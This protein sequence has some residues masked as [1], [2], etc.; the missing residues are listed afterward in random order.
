MNR[1]G[2]QNKFFCV[3]C[4]NEG[5]PIPRGA[6]RKREAGHLKKLWCLHCKKETNHV[7]TKEFTNY[8]EEQFRE[9]FELGRFVFPKDSQEP[10]KV[11]VPLEELLVCS[12]A[13]CPYNINGKCWNANKSF[14][15]GYR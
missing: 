5:I 13:D 14:E 8:D 1:V 12:K 7:E 6:D 4:G 9:E 2:E 3:E 15:C 11:R 10:S